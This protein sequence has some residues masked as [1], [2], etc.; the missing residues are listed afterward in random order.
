MRK[1]NAAPIFIGLA[2][3]LAAVSVGMNLM[4]AATSKAGATTTHADA[5]PHTPNVQSFGDYHIEAILSDTGELELYVYGQKE[6]QMLPLPVAEMK[7]GLEAKA[8][9]PGEDSVKIVV[10]PKPFPTDPAG[11]SA[12]FVGSFER[13]PDQKTVGLTVMIPVS[14]HTYRVQ[15]P[16]ETLAPGQVATSNHGDAGMPAAAGE[17]EAKRLFQTPG[18]VYNAADIVANGNITAAEKYRGMMAKHNMNPAPGA[19]ICPITNTAADKRFI[20]TVGGKRYEFCCTPCIEEFVRK[21]KQQPDT[22]LAP[23]K[24]VKAE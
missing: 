13:R 17:A 22:I 3:A 23:E 10:T 24:Y 21:A 12:R 6:R 5:V 15:W 14:G 20:W 16:P 1:R 4:G 2:L 7:G 9:I 18:G 11:E 19:K 8:I